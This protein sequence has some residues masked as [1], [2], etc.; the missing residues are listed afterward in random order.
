MLASEQGTGPLLVAN[1]LAASHPAA[2]PSLAAPFCFSRPH[3]L[4][5]WRALHG[6]NLAAVVRDTDLDALERVLGVLH[7]GDIE[8][9]DPRN[10]TPANFIQL[11]RAAQLT[12]DYLLHVQDRLSADSGAAKAQASAARQR[13]RLLQL[14][15]REV[16]EELAGSRKEVKHLKKSLRS[17]EVRAPRLG[18]QAHRRFG[19]QRQRCQE[20]LQALALA[21]PP[22]PPEVRLVDR[23]VEVPDPAAHHKLERLEAQLAQAKQESSSLEKINTKLADAL[24]AAVAAQSAANGRADEAVQL[25]RRQEQEAGV[26]KLLAALEM[27]RR[28]H[29]DRCAFDQM[30]SLLC[31]AALHERTAPLL[32]PCFSRTAS[33]VGVSGE[34]SPSL[35]AKLEAAQQRERQAEQRAE[36]AVQEAARASECSRKAAAAPRAEVK[37]LRA[38][39]QAARA[40]AADLRSRLAHMDGKGNDGT[41]A[42]SGLGSELQDVNDEHVQQLE[43]RVAALEAELAR[44]RA[45]LSKASARGEELEQQLRAARQMHRSSHA[46]EAE[47]AEKVARRAAEA[48]VLDAEVER[49]RFQGAALKEEV[50]RLRKQAARDTAEIE[51]LTERLQQLAATRGRGSQPASRSVSPAKVPAANA[52]PGQQRSPQ[53][54]FQLEVKRSSADPELVGSTVN[55]AGS[56]SVGRPGPGSRPSSAAGQ[57]S[58]SPHASSRPP[59]SG[60]SSASPSVHERLQFVQEMC[61]VLP[62]AER[63]GVVGRFPHSLASLLALRPDLEVSGWS[64]PANSSAVPLRFDRL[65]HPVP[66]GG[67]GGGAGV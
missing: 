42:E 47:A 12:L 22:A 34:G 58:R 19:K 40:E 21:R 23:I 16:Q 38:D 67:A 54:T 4:I 50:R 59:T 5:D 28:K 6:L 10:L 27:E 1:A 36:A 37:R 3:R 57:R 29:N 49:L 30:C 25:A 26:E 35:Q 14:K 65:P 60:Q 32:P 24:A 61:H 41:L 66:A 43:E 7:S 15:V 44:V 2:V 56:S 31:D 9:E 46:A 33:S 18:C 39:L 53:R 17:F 45:S 51:H 20:L 8:A 13:E 11:F 63:P 55:K 48:D 62:N 64:L 52:T